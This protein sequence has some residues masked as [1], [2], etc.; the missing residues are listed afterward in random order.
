[1]SGSADTT[2][3]ADSTATEPKTE[4]SRSFSPS[5]G[6]TVGVEWELGLVDPVSLELVPKAHDLLALIEAQAIV[7]HPQLH[8]LAHLR[9]TDA[10]PQRALGGAVLEGV[11]EQV[12]DHRAQVLFG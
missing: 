5:L 11:A 3:T 9:T 6:R 12:V 7:L 4:P 2:E 1:M 8:P 10:H